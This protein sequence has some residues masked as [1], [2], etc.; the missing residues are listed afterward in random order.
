M[1]EAIYSKHGAMKDVEPC[2]LPDARGLLIVVE[3]KR[4]VSGE[5]GALVNLHAQQELKAQSADFAAAQDWWANLPQTP[6]RH[7]LNQ[8]EAVADILLA[9]DIAERWAAQFDGLDG[10]AYIFDVA[11]TVNTKTG[12]TQPESPVFAFSRGGFER[13]TYPKEKNCLCYHLYFA[14]YEKPETLMNRVSIGTDS[15]S[16]KR[17]VVLDSYE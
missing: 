8:E 4:R 7:L 14:F 17:E 9:E 5:M 2:F 6:D 16:V 1:S 15:L 12:E 13:L 3:R 10:L 11:R